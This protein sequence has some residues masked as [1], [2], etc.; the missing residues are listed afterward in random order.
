LIKHQP[1]PFRGERW[2]KLEVAS[3]LREILAEAI[4]APAI[5][6]R[7]KHSAKELARITLGQLFAS[8]I[9]HG[10][11][12]ST[13]ILEALLRCLQE[14]APPLMCLGNRVY[15]ELS[16]SYRKQENAEF[17]RWY[18]DPLTAVLI[19]NL[20][21]DIIPIASDDAPLNA[22]GTQ[23]LIWQC[24][25]AFFR[26]V[27]ER[28]SL[29]NTLPSLLDAVR[30]DFE[31][32]IPIH[33]ANYAAGAF[34][35]HSLKP[36]VYR[37]LHGL[38]VDIRLDEASPEKSKQAPS[39][40]A[41][42]IRQTLELPGELEP[43]WLAPLRVATRGTDRFQ[44]IRNLEL[45]TNSSS[46]GFAG[47]EVGELF[48]GFALRLFSVSTDS[49][50]KMAVSTARGVALS[51][52]IRL[53]G[54]VGDDISQFHTEEWVG[55]YEEALCDAETP[56]VRRKLRRALQEFQRYLER[57]RGAESIVG[58]DVFGSA[59]GRVPVD[60]NIISEQE[61]LSIRD[62]F[63]VGIADALPGLTTRQDGDR[64]AEA[65][66]HILT[67]S[68]RCGLRR[69]EVLKLELSDLLLFG[70]PE[71]LVRPTEARTLKTKSSTRKIPFYALLTS[72]ELDRLSQW[73]KRRVAEEKESPF[74]EFLFS[75]PARRF[76]FLPQDSLFKML[77]QVMREVTGDPTLRFHHLRHSFASRTALLLAASSGKWADRIQQVLPGHA[78][79][80][81]SADAFRLSLFKNN[82]MTRRD[83][84]AVC[85]LLGHSSPEVSLEHYVHI[86]DICLAE[87]LAQEDI[88]PKAGVVISASG[89]SPAQAYR[90]IKE[91][92]LDDWIA[93]LHGKR[94]GSSEKAVPNP[95]SAAALPARSRVT[96]DAADALTRIW[97]SLL[98]AGT[99]NRPLK[100]ISE[101]HGFS[102]E[103]LGQY[104]ETARWLSELKISEAGKAYRHRFIEW[105]PDRRKPEITVRI[106]CPVKPHEN[107]DTRTVER[108]AAAFR[109]AYRNDHA[110]V[111][112]VVEHFA[113]QAL[114]DFG[115]LIFR[116]P[117]RPEHA[118][119]FLHFLKLMGCE[120]S[121]IE[122]I[123][124]DASGKRSAAV[125]AWRRAL[126]IH[127]S[128]KIK[129]VPPPSGRRNRACPWMG[130]Q[131]VFPDDH[132]NRM[133][134][135]GF[136]FVMV[137]AAIT[138][139]LKNAT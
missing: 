33:L 71:L 97:E 15:T 115:G 102:E 39:N 67:I 107:R 110:L 40:H 98:I 52:S 72:D 112:R 38:P 56:G 62:R 83:I 119:D 54:L 131:P 78:E 135:A 65:A 22:T 94:F 46:P 104:I 53:G 41:P 79:A 11:L 6:S 29:P 101:R 130:I 75:V 77:H 59:A 20:P 4:R 125:G 18:P 73:Q 14:D 120:N 58:S 49:K 30:L 82:R 88:A 86:L 95:E 2:P 1:S 80:L 121:E 17:R 111:R 136:R 10:G 122:F 21:G 63:T 109:N 3:R 87:A 96:K 126:G 93:H 113:K 23:G 127:S 61:F 13:P 108:L 37:R 68:Y 8:G 133:G 89:A 69:M 134:S 74:S 32:R 132:G 139:K 48:A 114:P 85:T 64:L 25:S 118:K 50:A 7:R 26:S 84:W 19:M 100:V 103:T 12:I 116:D 27:G 92:S 60:A 9:V 128:I 24:I 28:S 106:P 16:L 137:L 138:L 42:D 117:T 47:G 43:R 34:V 124:F 55:L 51:V 99:Q 45:L 70:L 36:S 90:H 66:W 35:C 44:I 105:T 76:T 81:A 129:K 123:S 57:E 31:S 5:L 91:G